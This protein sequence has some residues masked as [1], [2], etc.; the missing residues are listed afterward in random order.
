MLN[1]LEDVWEEYERAETPL[2]LAVKDAKGRLYI[3]GSDED[4]D[5]YQGM[6]IEADENGETVDRNNG[7]L[8]DGIG[9]PVDQDG[10]AWPLELLGHGSDI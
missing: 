9:C 5:I 8:Y 1:T 3:L 6:P 2:T 7:R 10:P 4:F